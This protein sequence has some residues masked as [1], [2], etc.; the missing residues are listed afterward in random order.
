MSRTYR[1]VAFSNPNSRRIR[2]MNQYKNSYYYIQELEENNYSYRNRDRTFGNY[3]NLNQWN[4]YGVSGFSEIEHI[5]RE[6]NTIINN[7]YRR[8]DYMYIFNKLNKEYIQKLR[9]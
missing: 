1:K 4:D 8:T 7:L 6:T 3:S 5:N 9:K 2:H